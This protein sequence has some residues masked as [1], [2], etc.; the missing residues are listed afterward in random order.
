MIRA[1]SVLAL[2][3][4]LAAC[5]V[6]RDA[7]NDTTTLSVDEEKVEG[8]VDQAGNALE[9]AA[10]EVREAAEDAGPV[11]ENAADRAGE[12]GARAGDRIENAAEGAGRAAENAGDRAAGEVRE[13]T[14]GR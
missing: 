2:G 4:T 10:N 6:N 8:A 1:A 7:Q 9:G 5:N 11:L 13:E 14:K 3:L 12:I